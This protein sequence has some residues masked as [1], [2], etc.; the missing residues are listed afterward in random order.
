MGQTLAIEADTTKPCPNKREGWSGSC[1][2]ADSRYRTPAQPAPQFGDALDP[3]LI[4][5]RNGAVDC[6]TGKSLCFCVSELRR[7]V[8]PWH[9]KYA[10]FDFRKNVI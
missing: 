6:T 3:C 8:Q 5:P 2:E 7:L 9:E 4:L 10:A 1:A